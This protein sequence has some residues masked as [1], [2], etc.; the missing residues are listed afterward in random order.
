MDKIKPVKIDMEGMLRELK[1]TLPMQIEAQAILAM[2]TRA[3]YEA[4][5]QVGFTESQAIELCK[6]G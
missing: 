2:I 4:F 6:G 3:K 5:L 1:R